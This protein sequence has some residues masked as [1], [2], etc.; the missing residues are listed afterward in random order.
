MRDGRVIQ[1]G[2]A[3][4][5][6]VSPADSYVSEFTREAPRARILTVRAVMRPTNGASGF[7][8]TVPAASRV[9]EVARQIES[10]DRD[11]GVIDSDGRTIGVVNRAAIMTVLLDGGRGSE[12]PRA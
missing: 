8:G 1:V 9:I 7:A 12:P 4:E 10:S 11:F 6:I 2:T 5:L 3:E